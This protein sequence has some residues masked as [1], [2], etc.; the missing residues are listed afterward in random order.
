MEGNNDF[1]SW[2]TYSPI[3][4][5]SS[6]DQCELLIRRYVL[7]VSWNAR[8]L[9]EFMALI[10]MS[11]TFICLDLFWWQFFMDWTMENDHFPPTF[12]RILLELFLGIEQAN[13]RW[14]QQQKQSKNTNENLKGF[15][16]S[17][18]VVCVCVCF[19]EGSNS[20]SRSRK[21]IGLWFPTGFRGSCPQAS[22]KKSATHHHFQPWRCSKKLLI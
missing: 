3:F 17:M 6:G 22:T 21:L 4:S 1:F 15:Y 11:F 8:S 18:V 19:F 13:P 7:N 16:P 9:M 5:V 2:L 14:L 12:G 20:L 10:K